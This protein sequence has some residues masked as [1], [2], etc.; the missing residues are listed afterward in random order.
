MSRGVFECL[1]GIFNSFSAETDFR[2]K[3]LKSIDVRF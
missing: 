1:H 2:R 3:N